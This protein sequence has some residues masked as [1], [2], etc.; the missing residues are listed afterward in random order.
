V[1]VSA[2]YCDFICQMSLVAARMVRERP[3]L[4]I[5]MVAVVAASILGLVGVLRP[6]RLGRTARVSSHSFV[7][8]VVRG[9]GASVIAL[10]GALVAA[11]A[12]S[13]SQVALLNRAGGHGSAGILGDDFGA[14][15]SVERA[16]RRVGAPYCA[17]R[18]LCVPGGDSAARVV[19]GGRLG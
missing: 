18:D 12:G 15:Q 14:V 2:Q 3:V 16:G 19:D 17:A 11:R 5:S 4:L 6:R 7:L 13:S 8:C 1:N 10:G 9:A